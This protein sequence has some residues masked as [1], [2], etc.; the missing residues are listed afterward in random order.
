MVKVMMPGDVMSISGA[1][2]V[3]HYRG[4]LPFWYAFPK[5]PQYQHEKKTSKKLD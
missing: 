2:D 3:M 1:P 4:L 5:H